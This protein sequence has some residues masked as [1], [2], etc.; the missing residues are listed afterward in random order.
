MPSTPCVRGK[1][2]LFAEKTKIHF[3]LLLPTALW[4]VIVTWLRKNKIDFFLSFHQQNSSPNSIFC[5][6]GHKRTEFY[7]AGKWWKAFLPSPAG[8]AGILDLSFQRNLCFFRCLIITL[9]TEITSMH[10][11]VRT[12][13]IFLFSV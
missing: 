4:L 10:N 13:L 6:S 3:F 5:A 2:C 1:S 11:E 12:P 7:M 9:N 8:K